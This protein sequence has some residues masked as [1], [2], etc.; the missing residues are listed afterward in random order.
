MASAEK[1]TVNES[2]GTTDAPTDDRPVLDLDN[3]EPASVPSATVIFAP[4]YTLA[5][6]GGALRY[7]GDVPVAVVGVYSEIDARTVLGECYET[8][9]IDKAFRVGEWLSRERPSRATEIVSHAEGSDR[10]EEASR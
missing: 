3:A 8:A 4:T 10:G 7:D 2:D 1:P 5:E 9:A 6:D